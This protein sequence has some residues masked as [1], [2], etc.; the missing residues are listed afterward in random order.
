[1]SVRFRI[2]TPPAPGAV[3]VIRVSGEGVFDTLGCS[4]VVPRLSTVRTIP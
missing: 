4:P 1:M 2:E 3:G